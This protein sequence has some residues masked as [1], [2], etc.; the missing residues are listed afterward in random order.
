ML[1]RNVVDKVFS[2]LSGK[3]EFFIDDSAEFI[4]ITD[5]KGLVV[6]SRLTPGD[7]PILGTIIEQNKYENK[8]TINK[9]ELVNAIKTIKPFSDSMNIVTFAKVDNNTLAL[10]TENNGEKISKTVKLN[11]TKENFNSNIKQTNNLDIVMPISLGRESNEG[12][13][14]QLN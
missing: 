1:P 11:I 12:M 8:F 5:S 2:L 10:S 13:L 7:Y 9:E 6:T 14:Y 4:K 3:V